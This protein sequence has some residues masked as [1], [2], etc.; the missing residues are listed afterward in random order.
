M[1]N[2]ATIG[3]LSLGVQ[4]IDVVSK[5]D[6]PL[7]FSEIQDQTGMSK[8]NLYK[9]LNTLTQLDLLYRD[10]KRGGF[11]LGY[12]FLEYGNS[13]MQNV[14]YIGR[15][16]PFYR[17]ISENTNMTTLLV[18]WVNDAPIVTNI[19]NTNYGLNLGAQIGTKLTLQSSAGKI[20]AAYANS[21]DIASWID[22]E[23]S[24]VEDFDM[25]TFQRELK[26]TRNEK[27]AY[28]FEP[29]TK[30]T[31]SLSFPILDFKEQL[32]ASLTL[33]GFNEEVPSDLESELVQQVLEKSIEMSEIYGYKRKEF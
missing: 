30:Y 25:I 27:F 17:E 16:T 13:A 24:Q 12:K 29:F 32:I 31:S 20:F 23:S 15:L 1:S 26:Q 3:S 9:Y 33:V 2:Q 5:S 21:R 28:S 14:D 8:S 7:R 4:I 10:K 19:W 6:V 22:K 11:A 18:T